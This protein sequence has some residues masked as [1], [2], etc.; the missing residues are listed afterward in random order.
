MLTI[1]S[2]Q[3]AFLRSMCNTTEVTLFIGKEGLDER[4]L[5]EA[6]NQLEARE[7]IKC[8]IQRGGDITAREACEEIADALDAAPVQT[9]GNR[10]SLYRPRR[11]KDP[12]IE[13]P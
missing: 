3:R 13:L 8:A 9:I 2:K 11:K 12:T 4:I 6:D 1:T 7:L 5:R 10:F